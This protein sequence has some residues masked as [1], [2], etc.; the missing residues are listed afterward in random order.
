M[1]DSLVGLYPGVAERPIV[2]CYAFARGGKG[3]EGERE[4]LARAEG[5]LGCPL[6]P[7]VRVFQVRD[8]SPRKLMFCLSFPLPDIPSP[9]HEVAAAPLPAESASSSPPAPDSAKR[10]EVAAAPPAAVST[11]PSVPSPSKRPRTNQSLA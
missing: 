7:A 3:G 8:V 6:G 1:S 4:L 5:V 10:K 2:H 9:V 11:A